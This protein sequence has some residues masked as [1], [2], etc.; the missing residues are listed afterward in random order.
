MVYNNMLAT[1]LQH[2]YLFLAILLITLSL[3]APTFVHCPTIVHSCLH[4]S[5]PPLPPSLNIDRVS[6]VTYPTAQ[7]YSRIATLPS[8]AHVAALKKRLSHASSK[9][10]RLMG[11]AVSVKLSRV[12]L[13]KSL[14]STMQ[15]C[16]PLP[17]SIDLSGKAHPL[18]QRLGKQSLNLPSKFG[19]SSVQ[20][21]LLMTQLS[22]PTPPKMMTC[23]AT[24]EKACQ[25]KEK[26]AA[27]LAD[28]HR[29]EEQR[30]GR[31]AKKKERDCLRKVE[32][33]ARKQRKDEE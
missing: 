1:V 21:P 22:P 20:S 14:L 24:A 28:A 30:L 15:P 29:M 25:L 33:D 26:Q 32:D 19:Q 27:E 6:S 9:K 17:P 5:G 2:H 7:S 13:I 31:I 18:V 10:R 8:S 3:I 16:P 4:L 23:Q 12:Q 11:S